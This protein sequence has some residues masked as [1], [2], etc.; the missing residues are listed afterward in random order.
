MATTYTDWWEW[1]SVVSK[2]KNG[3]IV[4][5]QLGLHVYKTTTDTEVSFS[6][7]VWYH[8]KYKVDDK[9]NK[10]Y[11]GLNTSSGQ[12][13]EWTLKENLDIYCPN[14]DPAW[15]QSNKI[16]L[17]TYI[18]SEPYLRYRDTDRVRY[19]TAKLGNIIEYGGGAPSV[20]TK[21]SIPKKPRYTVTYNANGGTG[22]PTSQTKIH[23]ESL[24]LRTEKPTRAGYD[25]KGW[26]KNS[27]A[28]SFDSSKDYSAGSIYKGNASVTLYAIW[29]KK[30]YTIK[31]NANGGTGAPTDQTKTHGTAI[32]LRTGKPTRSTKKVYDDDGKLI[33]TLSYVFSGWALT[34]TPS[35]ST[36]IYSPGAT[37]NVEGNKT[38]Y[39]V[40]D[41]IINK[42]VFTLKY[43]VNGGSPYIPSV[44]KYSTGSSTTLPNIKIT[45]IE[46][47]KEGYNFS[48]WKGND[49]KVYTFKNTWS[50]AKNLTLTAQ[51]TPWSNTL[52]FHKVGETSIIETGKS[53][54]IDFSAKGLTKKNYNFI[55]WWDSNYKRLFKPEDKYVLIPGTKISITLYP[56]WGRNSI[57]LYDDGV[58]QATEF[59]EQEDI[60]MY[61]I[62]DNGVFTS[63]KFTEKANQKTISL[64]NDGYEIKTS[65]IEETVLI[66]TS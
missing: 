39:A 54:T 59:I 53:I 28:T 14:N 52:S 34:S 29:K 26:S 9:Q 51:Y 41:E 32:A 55:G 6:I 36:K 5:S 64:S 56:V 3:Y 40:W 25:F 8:S 7:E 4:A 1:G 16:R 2:N 31:Y 13:V 24:T 35:S 18:T 50:E 23:G 57:R 12:G 45:N 10:L 66:E 58:C 65:Q 20:E 33:Y 17:A 44:K 46:P 43:D 42:Q 22:A 27:A 60:D 62:D 48:G 47:K 21:I 37:Y 11:Y 63:G 15:S 61:Q 49:G 38:L 30:T 19:F